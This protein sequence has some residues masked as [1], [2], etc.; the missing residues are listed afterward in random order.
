MAGVLP[1]RREEIQWSSA[2]AYAVG[3]MATDGCLSSDGRHLELTSKDEEQLQNF[4]RCTEKFVPI[5]A[6][7]SGYTGNLV[8]R[9]Q[10]SDVVLYR[11][12]QSVGLTPRKTHTLGALQIPEEYFFDFLRGHHDGDGTFY[13]YF[14]PRW[15]NSYMFYLAFVSASESHLV[16]IRGEIERILGVRGHLT[17]SKK[18]RVMQLKYAK[19]ASLMILEQMYT[20]PTSICLSRKR[21]KILKALRIVG[22]SLP[23][24]VL[25]KAVPR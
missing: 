20:S 23:G 6:K 21:L 15:K 22:L 9:I 25:G 16:W 24:Y 4:M 3:L 12:M 1:R 2:L 18:S 10:F 17:T 8:T 14:D 7:T 19:T 11:F 13:S 5:Q